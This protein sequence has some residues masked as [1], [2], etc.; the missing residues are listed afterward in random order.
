MTRKNT[1]ILFSLSLLTFL[2]GIYKPFVSTGI[3]I[4]PFINYEY[5]NRYGE[6]GIK[7]SVFLYELNYMVSFFIILLI[8]KSVTTIKSV[9]NI[10]SPFIWIALFDIFDYFYHYKQLSY[11]KLPL[12]VILVATYN[13]R[14]I[15][16]SI[17]TSK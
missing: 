6:K 12:L 11:I 1:Y 2:A 4:N 16:K 13:R 15:Y 10:I 3:K 7:L 14:W 8:C 5:Y 17:W 9:K